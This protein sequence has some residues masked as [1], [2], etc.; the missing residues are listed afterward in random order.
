MGLY[1]NELALL[2]QGDFSSARASLLESIKLDG[3]VAPRAIEKIVE[4]FIGQRKFVDANAILDE[5]LSILPRNPALLWLRAFCLA[6]SGNIED[7]ITYATKCLAISPD[8]SMVALNRACWKARATTDALETKRVFE[9]WAG[10]FIDNLAES[11]PPLDVTSY[12]DDGKLKIGYVSGDFKNHSIRYFIEPFLR[13]HSRDSFDVHAFMTMAEDTIS[14]ILKPLADTW[15]NVAD[16]SDRDLLDY[17]RREKIHILVDLSGH[18]DGSRLEVFGMRAAPVQVT[19]FGFMQT[20][21]MKAI[22]YRLTDFS[23]TPPGSDD[24]YTEKLHRLQCM[25]SYMPPVNAD[26]LHRMP[27]L[28]NGHVTMVSLNDPRKIND[29]V[30][31]AWKAIL[32]SN[33]EAGLIIISNEKEKDT[34]NE[35][36]LPKLTAHEFDTSRVLVHPRLSMLDFLNISS[37]AD[38]ALDTFPVSGGTVT[39]HSLWIGL[40]SVTLGGAGQT[41]M[42]NSAASTLTGVGLGECVAGSIEDY[43]ALAQEWIETPSIIADM[44][45]KCRPA[46]QASPLM[47]YGSRIAEVENAYHSMWTETRRGL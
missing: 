27:C 40:P 33:P 30:L 12:Q 13:F 37:V 20:L 43:V 42:N 17:I 25:V 19:W 18:T 34:A 28:D 15:H 5:A 29:D 1:K 44:R 35:Q 8:D 21:G 7:A 38:F 16:M 3:I 45:Q 2:T 41:G 6:Q 47:D 39:L 26:E 46:L 11:V 14:S 24:M 10:K 32:D 36:F 22:D 9:E 4:Y 31:G 23:I